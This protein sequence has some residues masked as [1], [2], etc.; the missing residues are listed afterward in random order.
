LHIPIYIAMWTS[1]IKQHHR[2]IAVL[3]MVLT[4]LKRLYFVF[5]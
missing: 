2:T 1:N 4:I 3:R 5:A